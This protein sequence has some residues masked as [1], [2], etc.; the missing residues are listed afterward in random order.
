MGDNNVNPKISRWMQSGFEG[1]LDALRAV[2]NDKVKDP[3]QKFFERSIKCAQGDGYS[4]GVA[5]VLEQ[6]LTNQSS[7]VG[8]EK[9]FQRPP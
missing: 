9:Y 2:K 1:T 5:L 4:C 3:A 8:A 6:K 7:Q